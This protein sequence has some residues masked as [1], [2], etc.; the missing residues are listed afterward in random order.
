MKPLF[1][2]F[3][4]TSELKKYYG[5][6]AFLSIAISLSQL[7]QPVLTGRMIDALKGGDT[8]VRTVV[9]LVLVLFLMDAGSGVLNNVTGYLGDRMGAKLHKILAERYFEH[10][11]TLPQSYFDHEL[12]GK[13]IGRLNRGTQQISQFINTVS[14]NFLQFLL[15][16]IFALALTTRYSWLVTIELALL[17]PI[18][19][20]MTVRTSTK[21]QK[22]QSE[23]NHALDMA[24][25]RFAEAISQVKVVKSFI[26]ERREIKFFQ[27][28]MGEYVTKGKPQSKFWHLQ[29]TQRRVILAFIF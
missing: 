15:T 19:T 23:R 29:D 28:Y 9:T 25:G 3:R 24:S 11:T 22:W 21:W 17:Y 18:F 10:L 26:Q 16:T 12:S 20:F 14:N 2:I 4:Y 13:I 7:L 8:N 5:L 1:N 6:I 27:K